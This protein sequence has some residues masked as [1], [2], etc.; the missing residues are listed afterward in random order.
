MSRGEVMAF[1]CY[2]MIWMCAECGNAPL[3]QTGKEKICLDPIV[4]KSQAHWYWKRT[5]WL[6]LIANALEAVQC[7]P[8]T[9]T[10]RVEKRRGWFLLSFHQISTC[11]PLIPDPACFQP[12]P[13][14]RNIQLC[15]PFLL[16]A[17]SLGASWEWIEHRKTKRKRKSETKGWREKGGK[18]STTLGQ[19][20]SSLTDHCFP[21]A[22]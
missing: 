6:D 15:P 2:T 9:Q 8:L 18:G 1:L 20:S 14:T 4:L 3:S 10:W 21:N 22:C 11:L 16:L 12:N 13:H 7:W 19:S 5:E 17:S